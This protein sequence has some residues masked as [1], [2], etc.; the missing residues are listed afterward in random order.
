MQA[1]MAKATGIFY[2]GL[3]SGIPVH[4]VNPTAETHWRVTI[5]TAH[6]A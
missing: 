1:E 3:F 4:P 5:A 2:G 6:M